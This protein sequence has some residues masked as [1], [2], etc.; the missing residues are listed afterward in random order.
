MVSTDR[1][2]FYIRLTGP[3]WVYV[4]NTTPVNARTFPPWYHLLGTWDGVDTMT[5]YVNG[6]NPITSTV[7][8]VIYP[9]TASHEIGRYG[10][11]NVMSGYIS[12]VAIF[13]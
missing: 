6:A 2:R 10:V 7:T 13:N 9:V 8:D 5:L 11:A 1:A 12:D 4:E 3:A